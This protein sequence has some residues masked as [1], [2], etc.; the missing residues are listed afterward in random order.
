MEEPSGRNRFLKPIG[1]FL[2]GASIPFFAAIFFTISST[3]KLIDLVA[4]IL[5]L[6]IGFFLVQSRKISSD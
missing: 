5:L 3:S 1:A 6:S 2:I 4:G